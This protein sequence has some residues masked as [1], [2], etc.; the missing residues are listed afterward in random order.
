VAQYGELDYDVL[1]TI[2]SSTEQK[3]VEFEFHKSDFARVEWLKSELLQAD[4][5]Q[6]YARQNYFPKRGGSCFAY[7]R[8]C[9]Y[10]G[11][12]DLNLDKQFGRKF[13]ELP[14]ATVALLNEVEPFKYVV[15]KSQILDSLRAKIRKDN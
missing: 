1:Y 12:C 4:L 5:L 13:S 2:Y 6:E 10:F 8:E 14:V 11:S 15:T 7:G 3:W 9:E